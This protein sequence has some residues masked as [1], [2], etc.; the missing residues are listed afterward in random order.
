MTPDPASPL[1]LV[2]DDFRDARELYVRYFAFAGFRVAEASNGA[3]ALS[4]AVELLPHV[5]LMDL[6]MPGMDGWDA[7]RRLKAH[8]R[9]EHIPVIAV[10]GHAL[11]DFR[12]SAKQAGCDAFVTKP[13]LP[14]ALVAEVRQLLAVPGTKRRR[15][16]RTPHDQAVE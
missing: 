13:C 4:K 10:T 3:E 7:T 11:A 2:V 1:V 8:P 16:K 15:R 14:E 6:S 12:E 5:I 9:T